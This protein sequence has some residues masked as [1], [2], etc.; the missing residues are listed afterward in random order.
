M[1]IYS[2]NK[3]SVWCGLLCTSPHIYFVD[4]S[5]QQIKCLLLNLYANY[6]WKKVYLSFSV[7]IS[8]RNNVLT[9]I[10]QNFNSSRLLES[11]CETEKKACRDANRAMSLLFLFQDQWSDTTYWSI[12]S[13]QFNANSFFPKKKKRVVVS[14]IF[15]CFLL[16]L[17]HVRHKQMNYVVVNMELLID[18]FS[19][20]SVIDSFFVCGFAF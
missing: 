12:N 8:S 13:I 1:P 15:L 11:D 19:L 4:W 5:W 3:D 17:W 16:S 18:I 6:K 2:T 20:E 10:G 7:F 14:N 9:H